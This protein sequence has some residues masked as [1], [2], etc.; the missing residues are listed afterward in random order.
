MSRRALPRLLANPSVRAV[1]PRARMRQAVAGAI[2]I[3][4]IESTARV[5]AAA[6]PGIR[7]RRVEVLRTT[8]GLGGL[9][10]RAGR[11][12]KRIRVGH[13]PPGRRS[14]LQPTD[15]SNPDYFHKVV[16]CRWACPA[17]P[18]GPGYIRLL[19][20]RRFG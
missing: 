7:R 8:A 10:W 5:T 14:V 3:C 13:R 11:V 9:A 4:D 6:S 1:A 20:A 16:D 17:H 12:A 15:I 19:A 18:P 2:L